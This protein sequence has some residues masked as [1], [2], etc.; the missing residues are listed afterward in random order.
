MIENNQ[1]IRAS[2]LDRLIT[3]EQTASGEPVRYHAATFRELR[4]AVCRDLE[5]LLN[6]RNFVSSELGE[7]RQLSS[8]LFVYG[9]RDFTSSNPRSPLL[10]QQLRQ[11]LEKV[12][13]CFEPRLHNVNIRIQE[14]EGDDR[15]LRFKITGLLLADSVAEPVAFDTI[16]DINRCEYS[17]PK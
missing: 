16:F 12:I 17:I 7:F 3:P 6:T 11:E 8:S 15:N 2:L 10:K 14:P 4:A 5:N 1:D 13:G 9:L